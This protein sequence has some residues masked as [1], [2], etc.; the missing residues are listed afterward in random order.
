MNN[1]VKVLWVHDPQQT[2][3]LQI[4][5]TRKS[6]ILPIKMKKAQENL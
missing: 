1:I 3:F 5:K 6:Q 4:T 2:L